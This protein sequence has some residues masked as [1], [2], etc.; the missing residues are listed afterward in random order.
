MTEKIVRMRIPSEVFK[1]Y[2]KICVE[3][4]LSV[5][6]QTLAIIENFV[7]IQRDNI[8]KLKQIERK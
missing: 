6:K 7:K 5:P 8:E 4:D 2:K 3:L 1:E